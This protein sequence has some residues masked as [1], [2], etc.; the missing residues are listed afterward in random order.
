M[1]L[2]L[3]GVSLTLQDF[4]SHVSFRL[5]FKSAVQILFTIFFYL[6]FHV[7][8]MLTSMQRLFVLVFCFGILCSL[9]HAACYYP[10]GIAM[11]EVDR[12]FNYT[13]CDSNTEFSMCCAAGN[14]CRPDG[15]CFTDS[16]E[17]IYRK[18][19]TD[20]TWASPSC[21]KLCYNGIGALISDLC[22][23]S[24]KNWQLS[25]IC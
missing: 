16:T 20:P 15:L 25:K 2:V 9:G 23:R 12:I 4:S 14:T 21:V 10:N 7:H 17:L 3:R 22:V 5:N 1:G 19:C 18:G 6:R 13:L 24:R 11:G 8:L